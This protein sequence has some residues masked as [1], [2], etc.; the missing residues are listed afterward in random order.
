MKK[1]SKE[2]FRDVRKR[3][4]KVV[5]SVQESIEETKDKIVVYQAFKKQAQKV[6]KVTSEFIN[7]DLPI[8]GILNETTNQMTFRSKD[9]LELIDLL[10]IGKSIYKI[11]SINEEVIPFSIRIDDEIHVVDC[12]VANLSKIK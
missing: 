8:Y 7:L 11:D 4:D 2:F 9:S 3:T 5:D 12:K 6:K 10:M 1:N